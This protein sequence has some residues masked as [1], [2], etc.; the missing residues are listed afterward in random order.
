MFNGNETS[1]VPEYC[2]CHSMYE[3]QE[4]HFE[5]PLICISGQS[6]YLDVDIDV[7]NAL[8]V[9]CCLGGKQIYCDYWL[10]LQRV[11]ANMVL[12]ISK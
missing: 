12:A 7:T 2:Q 8:K 9:V 4:T 11:E 5:S 10:Y 6:M 1:I 3:C